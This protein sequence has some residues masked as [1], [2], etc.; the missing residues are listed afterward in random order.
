MNMFE[1]YPQARLPRGVSFSQRLHRIE[2]GTLAVLADASMPMFSGPPSSAPLGIIG[3]RETSSF[4]FD[5]G[6]IMLKL[7]RYP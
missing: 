7:S 2:S 3:T 6:G 5:T 1:Q 4:A